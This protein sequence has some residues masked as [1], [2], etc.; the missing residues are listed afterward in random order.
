MTR[1]I[2]KTGL[3]SID[4]RRV[5]IE[6]HGDRASASTAAVRRASRRERKAGCTPA[7][8]NQAG[9]RLCHRVERGIRPSQVARGEG[10]AG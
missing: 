5:R 1:H 6:G 7:R 3:T 2:A 9:S 10:R 8:W 4:S